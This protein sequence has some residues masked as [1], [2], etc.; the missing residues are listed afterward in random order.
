MFDSCVALLRPSHFSEMVYMG[1]GRIQTC[2]LFVQT[3]GLPH[4]RRAWLNSTI[5]VLPQ[6]KDD[7]LF[8]RWAMGCNIYT[9]WCISIYAQTSLTKMHAFICTCID[10][11]IFEPASPSVANQDFQRGKRLGDRDQAWSGVGR[12]WYSGPSTGST[13]YEILDDPIL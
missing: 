3:S 11:S 13:M 1:P 4:V 10:L 9:F 12:S 5:Q 2:E 7:I 8:S 6:K